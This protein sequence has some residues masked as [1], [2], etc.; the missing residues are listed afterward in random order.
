M[1]GSLLLWVRN[2]RWSRRTRSRSSLPFAATAAVR[3]RCS[4][5]LREV[6]TTSSDSDFLVNVEHGSSLFDLLHLKDEL[7]DLLGCPVDVV[8]AGGLEE[9]A[10]ASDARRSVC[11]PIG[12]AAHA[13]PR[14]HHYSTRAGVPLR[15]VQEAASHADPRTTMRYDRAL[16]AARPTRH[17]R[18]RSV[19]RR[20]RSLTNRNA[21]RSAHL[22]VTT[23]RL[24][25]D[26][27][28]GR[29]IH[30]GA[31]IESTAK[32]RLKAN[33]ERLGRG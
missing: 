28:S 16:R 22:Q 6:R 5:R 29:V 31:L 11:E 17:P 21:R 32:L 30:G 20:R 13:P 19:P 23:E 25:H 3:L 24:A 2:E 26:L 9:R 12:R 4:D 7:T 1:V 27:R 33:G 8:S 14:L 15:D 18:G 10:A